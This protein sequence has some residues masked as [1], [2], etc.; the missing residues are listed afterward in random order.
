MGDWYHEE[1]WLASK[2]DVLERVRFGLSLAP[3]RSIREGC[4]TC[5]GLGHMP[6]SCGCCDCRY[7]PLDAGH[8]P[9]GYER[10]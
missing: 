7:R 3:V 10:G 5:H 6:L 1:D 9:P 4:E 8:A 2:E